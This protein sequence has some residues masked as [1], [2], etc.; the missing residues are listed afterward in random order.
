VL[1]PEA[2]QWFAQNYEASLAAYDYVG[3]MAMPR[4]EA[5]PMP[6]RRWLTRLARRAADT[7]RGLDGTVFEL[8]ARDWRTGKPVPDDELARQWTLLQRAGVRHLGYYPDDFLNNQ[9]SLEVVRRAISVRTLLPR[10]L[11]SSPSPTAKTPPQTHPR[12]RHHR[13]AGARRTVP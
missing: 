8:Q 9:P 6:Q 1:E 10:S 12:N 2:E 13:T 5:R 3:L 7:P 4:M 11:R